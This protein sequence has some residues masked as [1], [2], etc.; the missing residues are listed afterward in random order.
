MFTF[1]MTVY[2]DTTI[3]ILNIMRRPV[4]YLKRIVSETGHCLRLQVEP[5]Y[6]GLIDR[7][8]LFL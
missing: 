7:A 3:T 2:L 8:S 4:L 1:I 5:T 6:L